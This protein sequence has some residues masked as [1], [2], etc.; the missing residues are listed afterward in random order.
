MKELFIKRKLENKIKKF[1]KRKEIIAIRGARQVG[2]T[3]LLKMIEEGVSDPKVF[4]NLDIPENRKN[5]EENPLDFVKRFKKPGKKLF[6]F[7]DEIQ[8]LKDGG[9]KL[10]IIFDEVPD[11]KMLISGSSSLELKSKILPFLV[12]R[13]FLFELYTFGFEEFLSSRDES[14]L[15]LFQEKHASLKRFIDG[16][17][18]ITSPSFSDEFLRYWKD[19]VIFGG[20][21]EVVKAKETEKIAILKNIFDLYIE[22]DISTF[23]KIE[24]TGKFEDL[25]KILSFRTS[26]LLSVSSLSSDLKFSIR[27]VEEFLNILKHTY[28]I[29]LLAPFYKNMSTELRKARKVYFLDLGLRNSAIS[30]FSSFDNRTD[31]GE[32]MEN[33]VL[34]EL[35]IEFEDWKINYWRTTGK[36]E[37]DFILSK[38]EKIIPIEVKLHGENLGKSFYSFLN[39]YKPEKG[40][41][42]TL[43]KFGKKKIGKTTV[44]WVPVF[45]F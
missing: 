43:D 33:F 35:L 30:N 14:L 18:D 45:Y 13:A 44:Y 37:V 2:K 21:P 32:L 42:V 27:N 10:K 29:Y 12:G 38:E 6:L 28:V 8:R 17:G 1:I 9:E 41:I 23:F 25:V 22:R 26:D 39:T 24:D 15:K 36:A 16:S 20:Y 19:Y 40:I 34:R 4:I 3:T 5:L 31:K 11:V 7:L